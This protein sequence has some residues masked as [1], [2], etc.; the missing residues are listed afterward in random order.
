MLFLRL[1]EK[2]DKLVA[3][4]DEVKVGNNW[5]SVSVMHLSSK[6]YLV[7]CEIHFGEMLTV[8]EEA[9]GTKLP[10]CLADVIQKLEVQIEKLSR[11]K[12]ELALL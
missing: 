9:P 5:S 1:L 2:L 10:D 3:I 11:R 12:A 7:R 4:L 6:T 8:L